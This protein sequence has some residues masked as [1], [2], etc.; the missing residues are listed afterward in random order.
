M[1]DK[2]EATGSRFATPVPVDRLTTVMVDREPPDGH[3]TRS[4]KADTCTDVSAR[5]KTTAL[6][7]AA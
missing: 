3:P 4:R 6:K 2:R 1:P 7:L 5:K